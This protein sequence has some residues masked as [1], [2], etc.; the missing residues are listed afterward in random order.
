MKKLIYA[1]LITVLFLCLASPVWAD[2]GDGQV[3]FPGSSVV[4]DSGDE[5]NGD[6]TIMGGTLELREGGRIRGDVVV[7][8][9]QAVIDGRIDGT[10]VVMGGIL[11]LQSHAVIGENLVTFG[12]NVSRAEGAVVHGERI[13]GFPHVLPRLP[14]WSGLSGLADVGRTWHGDIFFSLLGR[15]IRT[16]FST[17][18][19][20]ALGVLLV[21]FLPKPTNL[22][23]QTVIKAPLP[24]IGVGLLT[25]VVLL[26]LVPLLIVI[27][28]GIPVAVLLVLAAVAAS[29]F[30]WIAIAALVGQRLLAAL[31]VT[32]AQPVLE[33]IIGVPV[34]ALLSAVPCLGGLL[35]LIVAAAGLGAVILTRFGTVAY[36][37][38]SKAPAL[39]QPPTAEEPEN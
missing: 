23:G 1:L 20:M 22:V 18:A 12:A 5:L 37:P 10:L 32:Q 16:V 17:I 11:D 19:L 26:I 14:T 6:M 33:V 28:I 39:E 21:L 31:Q 38:L 15:L 9:G 4:I 35:A 8:G 34:V 13:E 36:E 3:V 25:F 27:C 29:V 24:S 7:L 2:D 30:G